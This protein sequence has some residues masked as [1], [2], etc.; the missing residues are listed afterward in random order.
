MGLF[1]TRRVG[2]IP[3][4][5]VWKT[6]SS[7]PLECKTWVL[8]CH[9]CSHIPVEGMLYPSILSSLTPSPHTLYGKESPCFTLSVDLILNA[10]KRRE[11]KFQSLSHAYLSLICLLLFFSDTH[12][13]KHINLFFT[14]NVPLKK[15]I[16]Y[17][18]LFFTYIYHVSFPSTILKTQRPITKIYLQVWPLKYGKWN[19][20]NHWRCELRTDKR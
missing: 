12:T 14:P 9:S 6:R 7:A 4:P 2:C 18:K 15:K 20:W 19:C 17:P 10:S 13:H 3:F 11:P 16:N 1:H 5:S 8:L